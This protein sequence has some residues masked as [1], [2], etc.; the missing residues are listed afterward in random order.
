MNLNG[1]Q[2]ISI[3]IA[4]LGVLMIS[5]TQLTDLFGPTVTKSVTAAAAL[6]NSILGSTLAVL[7]SQGSTVK[8]VLAMPGVDKLDVNAKANQTLAELAVDPTVDKISA[9]PQAQSAVAAIARGVV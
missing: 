2:V 4:V 3:A 1:K 7:T 8:E 5:S 9:T 6:L